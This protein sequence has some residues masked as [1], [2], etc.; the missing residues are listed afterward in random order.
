MAYYLPNNNPPEFL[1]LNTRPLSDDWPDEFGEYAGLL[2]QLK[3]DEE[4][5][6][7]YTRIGPTGG[8]DNVVW[9]H[10]GN[11][12][13]NFNQQIGTH[14]VCRGYFAINQEEL[15]KYIDGTKDIIRSRRVSS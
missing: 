14:V 11:I 7:W 5:V 10:S 12:W 9:I 2:V 8:F 4:L 1:A 3:E 6:G 13:S 15:G